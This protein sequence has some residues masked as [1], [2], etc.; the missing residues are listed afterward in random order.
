MP[1][2][3]TTAPGNVL[4]SSSMILAQGQILTQDSFVF[5]PY[6][7]LTT[8]IQ[9]PLTLPSGNLSTITIYVKLAAEYFN[10]N[11]QT[12]YYPDLNTWFTPLTQIGATR[13]TDQAL[14]LAAP[15]LMPVERGVFYTVRTSASNIG[16]NVTTGPGT[17][18]DPKYAFVDYIISASQ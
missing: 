1:A 7:Y 3:S 5:A 2:S 6:Q 4:A 15:I 13:N 8:G 11:D 14:P 12:T 18:Q 17:Q 16:F 10:P 9:G